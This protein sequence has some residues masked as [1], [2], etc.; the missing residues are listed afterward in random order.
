MDFLVNDLSVSGQFHDLPNFRE[1]VVRLMAIRNAIERHG[2][3]LYCHRNLAFAQ[4]TPEAVMQQAIQAMT[5]SERR[6]LMVWLT[7]HGP[8]WEDLREH[9]ADDWFEVDGGIVTDTGVAEAA[10]CRVRGLDRDLVS[11]TP[12]TWEF[13]PVNVRWVKDE[14]THENVSVPNFWQLQAVE[15]HLAESLPPINSWSGLDARARALFPLLTFADDA[16]APLENRPFSRSACER[17]L[18]L[19][20]IL[21]QLRGCFD[22]DGVRTADGHSLYATFFSG[23]NSWFS[24]SSDTEKRE[25]RAEMTFRNP[26]SPGETLSCTWHGKVRTQQIRLH[27]SWPV[28]AN[29][30]LYL[31]Y[32]GPKITKR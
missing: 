27:F 19:L 20:N 10:M 29:S 16:F 6:A 21:N 3:S 18:V 31:V 28:A 11:V 9:S 30:P 4:V 26:D 25:F 15:A 7:R 22:D 13:T 2:F 8:F 32:V 12:S 1:A 14:D 17:I 24:D 5:Q 23:D